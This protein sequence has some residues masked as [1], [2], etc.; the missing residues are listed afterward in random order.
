MKSVLHLIVFVFLTIAFSNA[1]SVTAQVRAYRVSDA[2][3]RSLL[4]RIEQRTDTFRRQADRNLDRSRINGTRSENNIAQYIND[5]ENATDRLKRNFDQGN[6]AVADVEEVL[7]RASLIDGIVRNNVLSSNAKRE[8]NLLRTDLNTLA[9]YY[10]VNWNWNN[11]PVYQTGRL[12]SMLTGTY[13]LNT[14]QSDNVSQVIDRAV[15]SGNFNSNQRDRVRRNLERRLTPPEMIAI[16]KNGNQIEMASS[17]AAPVSFDADN[18]TR[19]ET[20]NN[21]R[22]VGVRASTSGNDLTINY[23]GDRM[24]DYFVSFTPLSNGQLRVT[25]RIYLENSNTTV[26]ANSVYDK[27][28]QV[29]R[30]D[31]VNS[32]WNN[33]NTGNYNNDFI[34]PNNTR[35]TA[36]LNTPVSTRTARDGDT[37]TMEVTSPV[38]YRG[39]VIEG[40]VVG[41]KSGIFSGRANLT[42]NFDSI[43]MPNGRTYRFAGLVERVID[44]DGD[45]V[46]VNNEGTVRDSN[47][48]TK[49]VTRAGI[50]AALGAIIGA[51]A[52]GGEGA[53]IGAA[54]GAGA[55]AGSVV[56][57]G[58]DN[59]ELKAGTEFTITASA[60]SNLRSSR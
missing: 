36:R 50:G 38:Q 16:S 41:E 28:D 48:T 51:I 42:L 25:R 4:N 21:N 31:S 15:S 60:P 55:G 39:A 33:N 23:E 57:Q 46:S 56:L 13:R 40:R 35:L 49:T 11:P 17:L 6:S 1:S 10:R 26:T 3:V 29:A 52:G 2:Q 12:D 59:L 5:F 37:F 24:N 9:Q 22:R 8:W 20:T 53:A 44:T 19:Y 45:T 7:S 30:W 43:R 32:G 34:V 47:Q 54:V 58:R 14:R 27:I 18:V